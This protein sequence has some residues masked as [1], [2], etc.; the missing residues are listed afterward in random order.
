MNHV[1][2]VFHDLVRLQIELWNAVDA[3]LRAELD[4][5]LAQF[6]GMRAIADRDGC[7]VLDVADQLVITIGGASK[8]VDRIETRGFSR[9]RA[10]PGD[11]R[12]ALL[13]LTDAGTAALGRATAIV[14]DELAA[15]LLHPLTAVAFERLGTTLATLRDSDSKGP[16]S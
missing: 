15:R 2:T 14:D 6:E 7:R 3:R 4:L 1:Q 8:L 10:N 16:R 12:S 9:R 13:E 11:G 5:T